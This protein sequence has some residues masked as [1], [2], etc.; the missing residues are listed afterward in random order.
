MSIPRCGAKG[1]P[2]R[3]QETQLVWR[4]IAFVG[5]LLVLGGIS[6]SVIVQSEAT[7]RT[8]AAFRKMSPAQIVLLNDRAEQVTLNVR[9]ADEADEQSSGFEGIGAGV[10][11]RS[12]ILV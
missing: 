10:I 1:G 9:V 6:W 12:V 8:T 4:W 11:R 5:F 2:M 3:Q 7:Y